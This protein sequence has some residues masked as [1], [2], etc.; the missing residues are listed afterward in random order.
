M[1]MLYDCY[2]QSFPIKNVYHKITKILVK[3]LIFFQPTVS[4]TDINEAVKKVNKIIKAD[5]PVNDKLL[6][7]EEIKDI[8]SVSYLDHV[9]SNEKYM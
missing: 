1:S 3:I 2:W 7:F 4:S 9:V 8:P 5:L 6:P